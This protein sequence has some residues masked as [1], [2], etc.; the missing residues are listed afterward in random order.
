MAPPPGDLPDRWVWGYDR[1][2]VPI[3]RLAERL[4]PRAPAGKNILLIGL[5][6]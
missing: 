1:K 6:K 4:L 5:K 2:I 3:S